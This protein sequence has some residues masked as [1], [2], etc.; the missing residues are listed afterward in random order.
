M[1]I[2]HPTKQLLSPCEERF[3]ANQQAYIGRMRGENRRYAM[4]R[5]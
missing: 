2:L 3:Q 5:Q 1:G 4:L